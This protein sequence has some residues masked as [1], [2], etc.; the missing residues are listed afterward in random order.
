MDARRMN[1]PRRGGRRLLVSLVLG[2]AAFLV[3]S[4]PASAAVTATF[5]SGILTVTGDGANN[6]IAISR[7]AAG[8]IL[9]N[10]GPSR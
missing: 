7:D 1:V 5:S 6:S 2:A 8:T 4:P 9:V 10:K 3:L